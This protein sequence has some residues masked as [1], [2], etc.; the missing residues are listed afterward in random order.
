MIWSR[1]TLIYFDN[2]AIIFSAILSAE[3]GFWP[4]IN[5]PSY[6]K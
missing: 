1:I 3:A 2:E 6:N 4:V 5:R